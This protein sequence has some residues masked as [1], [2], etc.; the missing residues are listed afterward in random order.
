[1]ASP[2]GVWRLTEGKV[3]RFSAMMKGVGV[4]TL[5][6]ALGVSRRGKRRDFLATMKGVGGGFFSWLLASHGGENSTIFGNDVGSRRWLLQ[7]AF[8]VSRREKRR[9]FRQ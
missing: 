5:Q 7:L 2:V 1:V 6:L 4:M 8:G 3:P 9:D